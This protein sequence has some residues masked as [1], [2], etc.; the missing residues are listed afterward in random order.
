M[1]SIFSGRYNGIRELPWEK[2]GASFDTPVSMTEAVKRA[3][4][5]YLVEK[6][7]VEVTAPTG[8]KLTTKTVALVREPTKYD[9]SSR[10]FGL[11]GSNYG[12]VQNEELSKLLAPLSD[13]WPVSAAG[14]IGHGETTF[15]VLRA[16][17]HQIAGETIRKYFLVTDTKTGGQS[18]RIS[19]APVRVINSTVLVTGV[20]EIVTSL[21]HYSKVR[22]DLEFHLGLINGMRQ[23][24]SQVISS[25]I[26]MT[27]TLI[28]PKQVDEVLAR[29]Y[30][31]PR[32]PKKAQMLEGLDFDGVDEKIAGR[33]SDAYQK[34]QG[35]YEY[36][37]TRIQS[38]RDGAKELFEAYNQAIPE[39]A[40]TAWAL[41]T[42]IVET[43]DYRRGGNANVSA[44]FGSRA[45]AKMR[46]FA[47]CKNA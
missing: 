9:A 7:S 18:L 11:V 20:T 26:R 39:F 41:Y 38:F 40:S 25:F 45:K 30:P 13:I 36:A 22:D 2:M 12:V 15:F 19:F 29:T 6:V 42:S 8:Q 43:E 10:L 46:A 16:S 44:L 27:E 4:L 37:L 14:S 1:G 28:S 17:D 47:A 33:V 35:G 31:Y 5:D 24:E 21:V 23:A 32:R 3:F 34:T